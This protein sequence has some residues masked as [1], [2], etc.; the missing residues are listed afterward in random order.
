MSDQSGVLPGFESTATMHP[1]GD[2]PGP[3][4][5]GVKTAIDHLRR[6]GWLSDTHAHI[7]A[8]AL[9]TAQ[10]Y[11]RLRPNEKAYG[12]AQVVQSLTKVFELLPTPD[13]GADQ[14]W[15]EFMK[16]ME[17]AGDDGIVSR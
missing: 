15:T 3:V 14:K 11:D 8:L 7:E 4:E 6:G 2:G 12:Y 16:L 13:A 5:T 1:H 9:S 17:G 10:K